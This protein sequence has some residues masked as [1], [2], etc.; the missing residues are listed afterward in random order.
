MSEEGA[1]DGEV[2][3]QEEF[4][5]R[6]FA[7]VGPVSLLQA[8]QRRHVFHGVYLEGGKGSNKGLFVFLFFFFLD[9]DTPE[10][11]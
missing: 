1:H 2:R 10:H 6:H 5:D 3:V 8:G 11:E 7:E 9:I 4:T